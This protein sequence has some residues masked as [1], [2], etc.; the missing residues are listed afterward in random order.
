[1][2][3][4]YQ[5][6]DATQKLKSTGKSDYNETVKG[7]RQKDLTDE[8]LKS[9]GTQPNPISLDLRRYGKSG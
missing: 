3:G 5:V 4:P 1:M 9:A 7:N 8:Q 2:I 6:F